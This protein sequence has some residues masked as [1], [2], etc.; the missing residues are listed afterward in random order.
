MLSED[1]GYVAR[2]VLKLLQRILCLSGPRDAPRQNRQRDRAVH[3]AV[4]F[5]RRKCGGSQA[6]RFGLAI[7]DFRCEA[8]SRRGQS[9]ENGSKCQHRN[10][11]PGGDSGQFEAALLPDI[12][13]I[14]FVF[15]PPGD[16]SQQHEHGFAKP[17]IARARELAPLG[18]AK[19]DVK[20]LFPLEPL[21]R[22]RQAGRSLPVEIARF[23]IPGDLAIGNNDQQS[24]CL[25]VIPPPLDF[26]GYPGRSRC[27]A[28]SQEKV[29]GLCQV[30][31]NAGP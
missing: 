26:F 21:Q 28:R 10:Q 13:A 7:T 2:G 22:R 23:S 6:A 1:P 20:R 24:F 3:A 14:D 25:A 30:L 17:P 31:F 8:V 11:Q 5:H 19:I 9:S 15:G 18:P 12:F 29:I 16:R 27:I 4:F